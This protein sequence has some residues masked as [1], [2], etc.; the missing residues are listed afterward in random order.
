MKGIFYR[1]RAFLSFFLLTAFIVTCNMMLFLNDTG[2]SEDIVRL[3]AP[4]TFLNVLVLSLILTFIDSLRRG[5]T[6]KRPLER[7]LSAL[8]RLKSGDFSVRIEKSPFF[9]SEWCDVIDDFNCLA[10][11]LS[12]IETLKNDFVSNVSHEIKTP[13]AVM[14]NYASLLA[15][16]SVTDDEK[17]EYIALISASAR[18]LSALV[19]NILRL[20]KLERSTLPPRAAEYDLSEQLRE[21]ILAF[22]RIWEEKHI[23]LKTEIPDGCVISSDEEML[24]LVWNNLLSNAFKFTPE[25]GSVFVLLTDDGA[26]A[27]VSVCDSGCGMSE[28][29]GRHIFEKFYQGDTSH[30]AEGNGLGLAL[31]KRVIDLVG[32]SIRVSSEVDRGSRFTVTLKKHV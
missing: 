15:S 17:S 32:G 27:S 31:V 5:F 4:K 30:C 18:R 13:L 3:R 29:V 23:R 8:S 16:P 25:N 9:G 6:V 22:E 1:L 11:K 10:E 7:I 12:E 26:S 28:E 24:S 2:I 20:N 14:Q 19:T 21:S